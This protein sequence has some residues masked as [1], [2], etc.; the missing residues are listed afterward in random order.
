MDI[1]LPSERCCLV[2]PLYQKELSIVEVKRIRISLKI[3][4]EFQHVFVHPKNL[5][6]QSTKTIFPTSEFIEFDEYYFRSKNNYNELLLNSSF[7]SS[8]SDFENL[9][10]LQTDAF[11]AR[12]VNDLLEKGYDYVGAP[13]FPPAKVCA[14]LT[15]KLILSPNI[16]QQLVGSTTELQV[17]NGGLSLRRI[18]TFISLLELMHHSRFSRAIFASKNRKITE[19]LVFSY[20]LEKSK[21][22]IP[23]LHEAIEIFCDSTPL[24]SIKVG[25]IYGFHALGKRLPQ[26]ETE[27]IDKLQSI[28]VK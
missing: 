27:I 20:F 2:T 16:L 24:N 3:N 18:K 14:S 10:I 9:L 11:L 23:S 25:K 15:G 13:F 5:N 4:P 7:Y 26:Y 8:F 1:V 6:I 12:S 28:A 22:K 19:D 21:L 17:G